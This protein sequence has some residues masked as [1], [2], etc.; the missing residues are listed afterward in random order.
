M[1]LP[2]DRWN[3][4]LTE[5]TPNTRRPVGRPPTRWMDDF[6]KY[7]NKKFDELL[8]LCLTNFWCCN[9]PFEFTRQQSDRTSDPEV[10]QFKA[11]Q[12]LINSNEVSNDVRG[13]VIHKNSGYRKNDVG[14]S[15]AYV[16]MPIG[17]FY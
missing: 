6:T 9:N 7:T 17:G 15:T 1:L 3:R 8:S 11:S 5:W 4:K 12:R 14:G 13:N 10:C 2:D 16:A